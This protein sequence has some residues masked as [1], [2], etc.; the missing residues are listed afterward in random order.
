MSDV[1]KRLELSTEIVKSWGQSR[2]PNGK[3]LTEQLTFDGL[4]LW[5]VMAPVMALFY[6]PAALSC[7]KPATFAQRLRPHVGLAKQRAL[8]LIKRVPNM[9]GFDAASWPQSEAFL[10]IGFSGYMYRDVLRPVA[11]CLAQ[12]KRREGVV[13]HDELHFRNAPISMHLVRSQ[14]IWGYW[15]GEVE[16]EARALNK[17]LLAA[18]VELRALEAFPLLIQAAGKSLW[19]QMQNSFNWL[20]NFH[21]PLLVPQVAIARHIL[22]R[23]RPALIISAD[24]ADARARVYSLL[25][26][27]L[28]IPSLEIQFGPNG[29]EGVEWQF[30]L[31]DRVATWGETTR[32]ALLEHGVQTEQ[33]SITGSPR[34]DSLVNVDAND[35]AKTRV[36]LGIP[37]GHAMVLC[38]STYQQKEYNSLSDPEL[39]VSMKRAVFKAAGQV[40]GLCLVV[41]PH[42]IEN[43]QE[44]R[45]LIGA[46][47]NI[48]LV[49]PAEDIRELTKACD[50]FIGFGSTAT[51]DAMIADKLTICP[52]FPGWIW[53]EMFVKSN[54]VLEPSSE[55]EVLSS[56]RSIVD[57]SIHKV[58]AE[59]EPAR[60]SFLQ[61]WTYKIDGNSSER[62]AML[63]MEMAADSQ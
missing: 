28:N 6:V 24:V 19:P 60:L 1:V 25:G 12:K 15:D 62:T 61:K 5:D 63:A 2:L 22:K 31:A 21:L 8:N 13:L 59:L 54:A 58:K 7:Q 26:R 27:Q 17:Q 18:I 11:E 33:I 42:P 36:R 46:G 40:S 34:H 43:V 10:F 29:A 48:L 51:V 3:S 38:A 16:N 57:G 45:R 49:D 35:V 39:L 56:L 14:S 55:E 53:S 50:A 47:C 52:A 9:R 4:S 37:A 20:F 32:K 30:L 44:T 23:H 41:K